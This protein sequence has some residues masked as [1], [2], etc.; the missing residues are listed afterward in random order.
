MKINYSI[1][2][3]ILGA[4]FYGCGLAAVLKNSL[5]VESSVSVGSDYA[6]A[7]LQGKNWSEPLTCSGA[8][9]LRRELIARHALE[10]DRILPAALA[11]VLARW[12]LSH[13][14]QP[15]LGLEC[16]RKSG[17]IYTFIDWGGSEIR[18]QAEKVIDARGQTGEKCFTAAVFSE[19]TLAEGKYG[20]FELFRTPTEKIY[21]LEMPC[22]AADTPDLVRQNLQKCW[23]E[24]PAELAA[25]QIIW[26]A[27]RI[28]CR[29]F[30]NSCAALDAGLQKQY[31]YT[32]IPDTPAPEN[33]EFDCVVAG[34]G[35][36]GIIAAITAARRGAKVLA[37]EKN[38]YPG[39]VW[40][41]GF[42][43]RSYIQ[44]VG[45]LAKVL[46]DNSEKYSGCHSMSESLKWELENAARSAGVTLEYGAAVAGVEKSGER[47]SAV[48]YRNHSGKLIKV[49]AYTFID[50]T[51][52]AVLCTMANAPLTYGRMYDREFNSY[53]N[54][55]GKISG[56][57]LCVQNFDAGRV[58]Q[59]DL[60]D[61][62]KSFLYSTGL[63]LQ[64]DFRTGRLCIQLSDNPG[65]REGMRI[66]PVTPYTLKDFFAGKGQHGE[67]FFHVISNL[68][69]HAQDLFLESEDYQDWTI[70][71]SCWEIRVSIPGPMD[72]LFP[73]NVYGV[74]AAARHLGVDHDLGCALRMI[75]LMTAAGE[76]AGNLAVEAQKRKIL[77]HEIEFAGIKHLLPENPGVRVKKLI[78]DGDINA[79]WH[80]A[81]DEEIAAGL[82]GK[83]PA[84]AIWNVKQQSKTDLAWKILQ[85]APE[86]SPEKINA[87]L[88]LAL[89]GDTRSVPQLLE[90]L[91]NS[92][93]A[94]VNE[95]LRFSAT[96]RIA[97]TYLLG[98]LRRTEAVDLMMMNLDDWD[99]EKFFGHTVIA[100]IKIADSHWEVRQK[101][102][103]KLLAKAQDTSWQM[104]EQ[105]KG[106]GAPLRRSDGLL[107]MHIALALDR[108]NIKHNI[109]DAV[110]NMPL[111]HHEKFLW[112][113]YVKENDRKN[114]SFKAL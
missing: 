8:E 31:K 65:V 99:C 76:L 2:T 10:N 18:I 15:L 13:H 92:D 100:L 101:I 95:N 72:L 5:V 34:L 19:N 68:D 21:T 108:W 114:A 85:T 59:Y 93:I 32:E 36:A 20:V 88:A 94:P 55:M 63:H 89:A 81:S 66:K 11:P 42:V 98:K 111:D 102:G 113:N 49:S 64:D 17:N 112:Q 24:R 27:S 56:K 12:C 52:D 73:E 80:S 26:S 45:G 67:A 58:A 74:I 16:I 90:I 57:Y 110:K 44:D 40:T 54:S 70:A 14:I 48:I 25:A 104:I 75:A 3:L 69:T 109:T 61:F 87:A 51:A 41:G 77:P 96:R 43:A 35:T 105:L 37:I 38:F 9:D 97:A 7:F 23:A 60:E 53:T 78:P 71:A 79:V 84:L 86:K 6:F 30:D 28:S 22:D 39:G 4:T 83:N 46:Q 1:D 47:V 33:C 91:K 50:S 29:I 82:S 103:T 107:R 106:D 62:S